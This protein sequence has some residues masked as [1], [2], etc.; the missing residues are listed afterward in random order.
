[1]P[2]YA[3]QLVVI[4]GRHPALEEAL[5]STSGLKWNC[6]GIE[7]PIHG[8]E[9]DNAGLA[10]ILERKVNEGSNTDFK[11]TEWAEFAISD[12]RYTCLLYTSPSPRD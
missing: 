5:Q 12:L 7:R 10:T 9:L 8:R 6:T 4:K 11:V 3:I 2:L 1:M